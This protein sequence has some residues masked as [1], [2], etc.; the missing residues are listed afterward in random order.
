MA[1]VAQLNDL[2]EAIRKVGAA[3]RQ[4]RQKLFTA[5]KI[6]KI[7][8][9][10]TD[11]HAVLQ[12]IEETADRAGLDTA[13]KNQLVNDVKN[14]LAQSPAPP[15][16]NW[17]EDQLIDLQAKINSDIADQI[18]AGISDYKT[19]VDSATQELQTAIDKLDDLNKIFGAI[20]IAVNLF[21]AMISVAA[22]KFDPLVK[23]VSKLR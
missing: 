8:W 15:T 22:G 10:L 1:T 18:K 23:A 13:K 7:Q 4:R 21:A 3:S 11:E 9:E 16:V 6:P 19:K 12:Y 14:L 20:A 17:L 2:I 5:F